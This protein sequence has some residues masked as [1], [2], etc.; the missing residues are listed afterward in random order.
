MNW[1]WAMK[2]VRRKIEW[3]LQQMVAG[4]A[5][6]RKSRAR[7]RN[8]LLSFLNT[9]SLSTLFTL[10]FSHFHSLLFS[11]FSPILIFSF[12]LSLFHPHHSLQWVTRSF[13]SLNAPRALGFLSGGS[14]VWCQPIRLLKQEWWKWLSIQNFPLFFLRHVRKDI[15]DTH[16][17]EMLSDQMKEYVIDTLGKR[18]TERARNRLPPGDKCNQKTNVTK[19]SSTSRWLGQVAW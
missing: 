14:P 12:C 6:M 10:S 18:P 2:T 9:S 5:L 11:L 4:G 16:G 7:R 17:L 1:I 13:L 3:E 19:A 8:L 15:I